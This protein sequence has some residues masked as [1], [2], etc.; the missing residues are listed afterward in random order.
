MQIAFPYIYIVDKII[1]KI[2]YFVMKKG[3]G[4]T[5]ALDALMILL[6]ISTIMYFKEILIICLI[7]LLIKIVLKVRKIIL[8]RKQ[9]KLRGYW[10]DNYTDYTC[11]KNEYGEYLKDKNV[12]KG[13]LAEEKI[14]KILERIFK[15]ENIIH[16]SYFRD[17]ELV[18]TQVDII[19]IDS[20]G[21]YIIESKAYSSIIAGKSDEKMWVQLFGGKKYK[22][23]PNPINQNT[24]H[25][26]AIKNNLK[27]FSLPDNCFKSYIVFD[28]NCKLDISIEEDCMAKVIQQKDLLYTILEER[29]QAENILTDEIIDNISRRFRAHSDIDY[30][31][32]MEHVKRRQNNVRYVVRGR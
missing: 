2:Y 3:S 23:F 4:R 17:D 19:A 15:R 24:R 30:K 26:E 7:I 22:R 6:I 12:Q 5:D 28:N 16:D 10:R 29:K 14:V 8:I 11:D 32:K 21:I 27:E 9:E 31:I 20:T 25:L 18:T 1:Q 13:I